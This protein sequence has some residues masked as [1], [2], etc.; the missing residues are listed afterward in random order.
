MQLTLP[1]PAHKKARDPASFLVRPWLVRG[2]PAQRVVEEGDPGG[3]EP[4][5]VGEGGAK[6]CALREE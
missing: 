5:V 4:N 6:G 3:A 1:S 2:S